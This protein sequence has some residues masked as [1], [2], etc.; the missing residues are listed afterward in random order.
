MASHVN[1]Q[2]YEGG[3]FMPDHGLF[4]G[5]KGAARQVKA[6]QFHKRGRLLEVGST[7]M[8][9]VRMYEGN[10]AWLII[11]AIIADSQSDAE[12]AKKTIV[13]VWGKYATL[14]LRKI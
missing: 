4:C 13:G 6:E 11:G 12:T 3:E 5:K 7:G 1:G 8:Y 2:W 9:E 14:V 10:G